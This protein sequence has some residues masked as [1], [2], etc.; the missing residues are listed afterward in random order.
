MKT[1][2]N[3]L[4]GLALVSSLIAMATWSQREDFH[5]TATLA[6]DHEKSPAAGHEKT[7]VTD[8]E[9][10]SMKAAPPACPKEMP[11]VKMAPAHPAAKGYVGM[12]LRNNLIG[13]VFKGSPA[14]KAGIREGDKI[15]AIDGKSTCG[16]CALEIADRIVGSRGTSVALVLERG[17]E[18]R[19]QLLTRAEAVPEEAQALREQLGQ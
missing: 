13:K 16:L 4:H 10:T 11:S 2:D 8:L 9:K 12:F 5:I 19:N 3:F 17:D 14:E 15:M 1:L 6:F 7:S 18:Q